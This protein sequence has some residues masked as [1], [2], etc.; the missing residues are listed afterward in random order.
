[1]FEKAAVGP[2][3]VRALQLYGL[4]FLSAASGCR[5]TASSLDGV[6]VSEPIDAGAGC[7][8]FVADSLIEHACFHERVGPYV[9]DMAGPALDAPGIDVNRVHTSFH[10]RLPEREGGGYRGVVVYQPPKAGDYA[11]FVRHGTPRIADQ[12]T[13]ITPRISHPTEICEL[14]PSVLV[15][16]LQPRRHTIQLES[17]QPDVV[18]VIE[19]LNEGTAADHYRV[20]CR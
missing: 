16:A 20:D 12:G 5:D 7:Q 3:R 1:M 18:L 10:L 8:T 14:L 19:S 13:T 15:F 4:L 9:E 6:P 11:V 2:Q 17:E